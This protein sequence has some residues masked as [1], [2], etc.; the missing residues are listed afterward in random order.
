MLLGVLFNPGLFKSALVAYVHYLCIL[1]CFGALLF[2]RV[3]L[4]TNLKKQEII[5][6]ILA[7][8]IYGL[9]G[10]VLLASGILRVIYFGKGGD[11]YTSNPIFWIK[12]GLFHLII[13]NGSS[14]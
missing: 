14:N 13:K 11:F 5:S 8:V 2:E 6:I 10:V 1:L 4:K 12:V 7:D 3:C 9:A